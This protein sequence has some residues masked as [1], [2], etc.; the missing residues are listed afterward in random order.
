MMDGVSPET[1]WTITK[2]WNN[3]F[4]YKVASCW[5]FLWDFPYH[6]VTIY[7]RRLNIVETNFLCHTLLATSTAAGMI[8]GFS[9]VYGSEGLHTQAG[10]PLYLKRYENAWRRQAEEQLL[11]NLPPRLLPTRDTAFSKHF[12]LCFTHACHFHYYAWVWYLN[13]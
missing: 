10:V 3:T 13:Q 12:K 6:I 9:A 5:F 1:C 11:L 2:H 8:Q 4:Y 7:T